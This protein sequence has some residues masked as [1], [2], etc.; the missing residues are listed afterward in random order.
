VNAPYKIVRKLLPDGKC[1]LRADKDNL[2][3]VLT[4]FESRKKV[5]TSIIDIIGVQIFILITVFTT[6]NRNTEVDL[7]PR[8]SEVKT[9]R[10]FIEH[11]LHI[12]AGSRWDRRGGER[13]TL[14]MDGLPRRLVNWRQ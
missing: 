2:N 1:V 11:K 13:M 4:S 5:L 8:I 9:V 7:R 10:T 6:N 14:H 3:H 12:T